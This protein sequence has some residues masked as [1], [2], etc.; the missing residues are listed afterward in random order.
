MRSIDE[1]NADIRSKEAELK[2]I[3]QEIEDVE[4]DLY[5]LRDEEDELTEAIRDAQKELADIAAKERADL[6]WWNEQTALLKGGAR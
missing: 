5:R 6:A 3:E 1:I 2:V 4:D